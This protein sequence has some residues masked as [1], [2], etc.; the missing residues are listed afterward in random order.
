MFQ[1]WEAFICFLVFKLLFFHFSALEP[2]QKMQRLNSI[3]IYDLFIF[4]R[5]I[6]L[7]TCK[8][9]VFFKEYEKNLCQGDT[10]MALKEIYILQKA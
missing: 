3:C 1:D 10:R 2:K 6:G 5:K 7:F 4:Y 9:N 8:S